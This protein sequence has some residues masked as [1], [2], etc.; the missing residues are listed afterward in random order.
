[1]PL[2]VTK[3]KFRAN[4]ECIDMIHDRQPFFKKI[5]C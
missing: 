2:V 1:M 4:D 3:G 5:P